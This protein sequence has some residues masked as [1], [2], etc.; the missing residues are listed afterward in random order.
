MSKRPFSLKLLFAKLLLLAGSLLFMFVT[1]EVGL[2][3]IGAKPRS[4]TV[5]TNFYQPDERTGW[6]GRPNVAMR[7]TTSDFDVLATHDA[8]GLRPCGLDWPI[9][10]DKQ[11]SKKIVWCL[12]DSYTWG[13]GV[14]DDKTWVAQL[15]ALSP[16]D[17]AFRNLGV[18]G[19][20]PLQE[21][22]QLQRQLSLGRKPAAVLVMF[23]G[24]D[25]D[26][27]LDTTQSKPYFAIVEGTAELRNWPTPAPVGWELRAW[28]KRNLLVYNYVSYYAMRAKSALKSWRQTRNTASNAAPQ[29]ATTDNAAPDSTADQQHAGRAI[30][31]RTAYRML[32]E[33]CD[34]HDFELIVATFSSNATLTTICRELDLPLIDISAYLDRP[35]DAG[36]SAKP[37]NFPYDGHWTDLGNRLAAEGLHAE[38]NKFEAA[39]TRTMG[40]RTR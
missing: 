19:F 21:Y 28:L 33:L 40:A 37:L 11:S 38:L 29:A 5:L 15:N 13:H 24:N 10:D 1:G 31:L 9:D 36:H 17:Y 7:F 8:D 16:A 27:N 39:R 26:D 25:P 20:S 35:Q 23:C 30:A 6:S 22:F 4:A 34:E 2:R 12:G 18:G 3:L 14:A 32:K